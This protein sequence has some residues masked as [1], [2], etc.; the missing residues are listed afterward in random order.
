MVSPQMV[1]HRPLNPYESLSME[2]PRVAH[3]PPLNPYEAQSM[4][5]PHAAHEA[6][7]MEAPQAAQQVPQNRY[8]AQ[9]MGTQQMAQPARQSAGAQCG[10]PCTHGVGVQ[11]QGATHAAG[12]GIP[13]LSNNAIEMLLSG[14]L[15][16]SFASA[17]LVR[18]YSSIFKY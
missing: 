10:P 12:G 4:A 17:A 15:P 5:A 1:Q 14:A 8:E 9:A 18:M 6:Q 7:A 11:G 16:G 13:M 3:H 2:A